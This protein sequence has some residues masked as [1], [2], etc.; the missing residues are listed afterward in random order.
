MSYKQQKNYR[1]PIKLL[2]GVYDDGN[3]IVTKT[4]EETDV[5]MNCSAIS[6]NGTEKLVNDLIVI[7]DTCMIETYYRPDITSKDAIKFLDDNSIYEIISP[8][9]DINR[10]HKIL[11]FKVRRYTG[12]V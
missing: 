10:E 2:K 4:Y 5:I 11:L 3:G 1:T 8:P 9:Q 7:E 12:G 6:Y